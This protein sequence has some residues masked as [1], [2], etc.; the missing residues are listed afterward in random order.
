MFC[1]QIY[2]K[3]YNNK[4]IVSQFLNTGNIIGFGAGRGYEFDLNSNLIF[5]T[6]DNIGVHHYIHKTNQDTYF[7]IDAEIQNLP[8]PEECD[9]S[10][11]DIIPWQGDRFIEIDEYGDIIKNQTLSATYYGDDNGWA[12]GLSEMMS[13]AGYMLSVA[14]QVDSTNETAIY[15]LEMYRKDNGEVDWSSL[16]G[17]EP[18]KK[19]SK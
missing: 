4:I 6:H 2:C 8:C 9:P 10:L 15:E 18:K 17:S 19:G 1:I 16:L 5:E 7:L 3:F 11:P 12:G 13:G 14:V